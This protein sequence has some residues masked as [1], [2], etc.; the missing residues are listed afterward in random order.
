MTTRV[1]LAG[2][3]GVVGRPLV[4]LLRARGHHVT[5]LVRD[6]A[7]AAG[8][9]LDEIIVAD[10]LDEPTVRAVVDSARPDVVLHQLTA[11]R[12]PIALGLE[13]TS[14][15]RTE[16]TRILVEAA[17]AAGVGKVV[18]QSISFCTAPIGASVLTEDAPLYLDAPNAGWAATVGAVAEH[19]RLVLNTPDVTGIVLRYGTLYGPGTLY[20][21]TGA[22]GGS[23]ARGRLPLPESAAGVMSFLHVEDAA[24]AAVDAVGA[25]EANIS[26]LFNVADDEPAAA[27]D[28]LPAYAALLGAPAPRTV[29]TKMAERL[30]GW[31]PAYQLTA[32]RGASTA[33]AAEALGWKPSLPSW[34]ARLASD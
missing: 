22:V 19:E 2:A 11:L 14:R 1:L 9:D 3:T 34:R 17:R 6:P 23:V 7:R 25:A 24:R 21:S 26:G 31:F 30:L 15:L 16:G 5:A 20:H 28:W 4:P 33:R 12:Q 13:Q 10:A 32:L 29:P 27:T 8:L 18:A